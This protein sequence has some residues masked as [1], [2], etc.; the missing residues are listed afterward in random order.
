MPRVSR[1][2]ASVKCAATVSLVGNRAQLP[3]VGRGGVLDM[4]AQD[5]AAQ[6]RGATIDMTGVHR[7][8]DPDYADLTVQ[9]RTGSNGLDI[10]AGDLIQTRKNNSVLQ[11]ANRQTWIVQHVEDDGT[12]WA[13]ETGMTANASLVRC[14][15]AERGEHRP[16]RS[17][18]PD[19][20]AT[21]DLYTLGCCTLARLA[22][23]G[24]RLVGGVR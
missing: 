17:C 12:V 7:F 2:M 3:A 20:A 19:A 5:M 16:S 23:R 8:T 21:G 15:T 1:S 9:M 18:A 4:A 14:D 13:K 6:I 24:H 11:V 22:Q 10:G